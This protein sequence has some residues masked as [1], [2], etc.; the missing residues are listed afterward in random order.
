M[1]KRGREKQ[2]SVRKSR[3]AN[4]DQVKVRWGSSWEEETESQIY[5]RKYTRVHHQTQKSLFSSTSSLKVTKET[6]LTDGWQVW[7]GRG[8][9]SIT[10]GIHNNSKK[11]LP[12]SLSLTDIYKTTWDVKAMNR[13]PTTRYVTTT[14]SV[15][16]DQSTWWRTGV[17]TGEG[18]TNP[19]RKNISPSSQWWIHRLWGWDVKALHLNIA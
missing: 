8:N 13:Q 18:E 11:W 12:F 1:D 5:Y 4:G 15:Q 6:H 17:W 9:K 16:W 2:E 19:D 3:N 10:N 7:G 14:I